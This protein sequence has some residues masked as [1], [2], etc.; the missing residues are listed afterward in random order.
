MTP[1]GGFNQ[2]VENRYSSHTCVYKRFAPDM[3]MKG[4]PY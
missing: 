3:L 4:F 1:V 2:K